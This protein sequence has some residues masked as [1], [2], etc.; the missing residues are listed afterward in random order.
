[1][2]TREAKAPSLPA[3]PCALWDQLILKKLTVANRIEVKRV[4]WQSIVYEPFR[5]MQKFY[6]VLSQLDIVT[7]NWMFATVYSNC[8]SCFFGGGGF[9]KFSWG[10]RTERKGMW[11]GNPLVRG[12]GGS[13]NLVQEIYFHIVNFLIFGTLRLFMITAS[14]F[15]IAN[16][17]QLRT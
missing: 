15:V 7:Q 13:R 4:C 1:M 5:W 9:N 8:K 10:Q 2:R 6:A 3:T 16:V 14:L 11:G 17:K 12:S